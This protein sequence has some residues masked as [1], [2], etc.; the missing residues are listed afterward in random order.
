MTIP[1]A[2]MLFLILSPLPVDAQGAEGKP[3]IYL[4]CR[5]SGERTVT[6][7]GGSVRAPGSKVAGLSG[8]AG[9][10]EVGTMTS[11]KDFSEQ[12]DVSISGRKGRVRL[13]RRFLP[14]FNNNRN[15]WVGVKNLKVKNDEIT[16]N[17]DVNLTN[18]PRLRIDR[19]AGSITMDGK[20]GAF[21]GQC[22]LLDPS[23]PAF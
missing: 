23:N 18:S 9:S 11:R 22:Q 13:P 21:Y 14:F 15:G 16:G 19:L 8:G 7:H 12:M 17:I 6:N 4:A 1:A 5:G 10:V 20:V 2:A 3:N